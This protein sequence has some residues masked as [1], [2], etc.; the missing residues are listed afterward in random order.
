[1]RL[2]ANVASWV[3]GG[4][5]WSVRKLVDHHPIAFVVVLDVVK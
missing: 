2:L 4:G 3:A 1:M 5:P